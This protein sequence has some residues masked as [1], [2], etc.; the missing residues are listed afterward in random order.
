MLGG[1]TN[2][3]TGENEDAWLLS[4]WHL[5]LR[6]KRGIGT[7]VDLVDTRVENSEEITGLSFYYLNDLAP[8]TR[9]SG[10]PR[11]FVNEDRYRVE[12]KYRVS[13][14][15][16]D[17]AEWRIDSNLTLLSDR[18]YLEDFDPQDYRVDPERR[19]APLALRPFPHQR[20]LPGGHAPAGN[21]L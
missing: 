5:D 3:V 14:D 19:L 10:V 20:L 12:L 8:D 15:F 7:G 1:K 16:P 2:E 9:R 11:G 17:D 21:R 13:P 18:H 4:R 6:S